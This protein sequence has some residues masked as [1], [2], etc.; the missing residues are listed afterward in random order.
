MLNHVQGLS[1]NLRE[2]SDS[3][4]RGEL[5]KK[6]PGQEGQGHLHWKLAAAQAG[7]DMPLVLWEWARAT[8]AAMGC[9]RWGQR[10]RGAEQ[11]CVLTR[12]RGP[13]VQMQ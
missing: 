3:D 4:G 1:F 5:M 10:L 7:G 12:S 9:W 11:S 2:H 8:A 13:S 6:R